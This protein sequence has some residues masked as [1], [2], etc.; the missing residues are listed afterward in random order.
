M[1]WQT[2]SRDVTIPNF[3]RPSLNTRGPGFAPAAKVYC[4][5]DYRFDRNF[6][7]DGAVRGIF[8][9]ASYLFLPL[10]RDY[11]APIRQQGRELKRAP[12]S[13]SSMLNLGGATF[14]VGVNLQFFRR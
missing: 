3:Y 12:E 9:E 5:I 7:N 4:G 1:E 14:T 13:N 10:V 2:T 6:A 11:F 8:L